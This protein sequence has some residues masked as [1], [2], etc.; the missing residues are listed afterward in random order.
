MRDYLP[1]FFAG[2]AIAVAI[3]LVFHQK[4]AHGFWFS[5]RGAWHH[6]SVEACFIALAIGLLLGKY[7]GKRRS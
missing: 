5:F 7:L 1:E 3:L 2:I 4:I 6:E